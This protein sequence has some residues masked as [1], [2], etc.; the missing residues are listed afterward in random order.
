MLLAGFLIPFAIARAFGPAASDNALLL[1]FRVGT[2]RP[3]G[4]GIGL[5][6]RLATIG[7][8]QF[9]LRTRCQHHRAGIGNDEHCPEEGKPQHFHGPFF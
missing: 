9:S 3:A 2:L 7:L 1:L 4:I 8:G 5:A 6:A